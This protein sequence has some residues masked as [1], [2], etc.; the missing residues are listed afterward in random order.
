MK[1]IPLIEE[2][3]K[4]KRLY[5]F[6]K[7]D[8]ML[9][10]QTCENPD[11]GEWPLCSEL[12]KN[13]KDKTIY[14]KSG[15]AYMVKLESGCWKN[16]AKTIDSQ[17]R[18]IK[19][20]KDGEG[21]RLRRQS[22]NEYERKKRK[23]ELKLKDEKKYKNTTSTNASEI[24]K[25]L[26]SNGYLLGSIEDVDSNFDDI[27]AKAFGDF[28][29]DKLG[30]EVNIE[31]LNDLQS[32]LDSLGLPTGL[33]GYGEKVHTAL[34]W[35]IDFIEN[36]AIDLIKEPKIN[37]IVKD[38]TNALLKIQIG[39]KVTN[40]NEKAK[41]KSGQFDGLDICD[42]YIK[43]PSY[44]ISNKITNISDDIISFE[45]TIG[46]NLHIGV[47]DQFWNDKQQ[48]N[49]N[50]KD[51][52]M[53]FNGAIKYHFKIEDGAFCIVLEVTSAYVNGDELIK[54]KPTNFSVD[55]ILNQINLH[56]DVCNKGL[57]RSKVTTMYTIPLKSKINNKICNEGYCLKI[58]DIIKLLR[59]KRELSEVSDLYFD[60]C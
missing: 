40:I 49:I 43:Y 29:K 55:I 13:L 24:Q 16:C 27:T 44:M 5:N 57:C 35:I 6:K 36:G 34:S 56:F 12:I 42:V 38:L 10:E 18:L 47:C 14:P 20:K 52:T 28:M 41:G 15:E 21:E 2:I 1:K 39:E 59:G 3:N 37:S 23:E 46:G 7:G 60:K 11:N 30:V 33:P 58:E 4:I 32:Y 31:T 26:I 54:L 50:K 48:Y 9:M 25:F 19:K 51:F 53:K 45:G 8:T 22:Y 17:K